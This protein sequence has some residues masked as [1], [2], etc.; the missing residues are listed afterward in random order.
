MIS[1]HKIHFYLENIKNEYD[2]VKNSYIKDIIII[3]LKLKTIKVVNDDNKLLIW[4]LTTE[5]Q[6][7]NDDKNQSIVKLV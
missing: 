1:R 7:I 2:G 3:I 5:I 6:K 4:N